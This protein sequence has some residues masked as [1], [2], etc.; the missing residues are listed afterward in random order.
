MTVIDR[1]GWKRRDACVYICG[2]DARHE[3]GRHARHLRFQHL[4]RDWS[5]DP[6]TRGCYAG[7]L[8]PGALTS[9]GPA[10]RTPVGRIHWAGTETAED[11]NGY[12]EG[13]IRSGD[14]AAD[15]VAGA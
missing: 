11:W 4:E 3:R 6:W 14:R 10:L 5:A 7:F 15:E 9:Y 2:G 1:T 8:P 13:A 12:I